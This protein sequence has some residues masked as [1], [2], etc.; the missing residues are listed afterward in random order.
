MATAAVRPA[1]TPKTTT[2][3][4][5]LLLASFA[6]A[7]FILLGIFAAGYLV[8]TFW[9]QSVEPVIRPAGPF[10]SGFLRIVVQLAALGGLVYVGSM[11]SGAHPPKGLRGGIFLTISAAVASFFIARAI[12]LNAGEIGGVVFVGAFVVLL[13]VSYRLLA[14]PKAVR[15]MHAIEEQG[16]LHTNS[17]KRTQGLKMRRYTIIGILIIGL[18]GVWALLQQK[19]FGTGNLLVRIPGLESAVTFLTD[20]EYSLP[21]LI[22]AGVLWLAW[23]VVNM[24]AFTDFLI[25][26]EAEMNKVS[27]STRKRLVQDTVVVL[28]VTM[29]LTVFLLAV[30]LFWG[31]TLSR[32]WIGVLPSRDGIQQK[33]DPQGKKS[34]W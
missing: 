34:E 31:W 30:D 15:W 8:P 3:T 5:G 13:V 19:T 17:Y 24:P 21:L 11:L 7:A 9:N 25:A 1:P 4:T 2:A 23:R 33:A 26:T 18:S 20:K 12:G 6:G 22:G 27:W 16:W 32:P 28:V 29:L 14:S 10:V